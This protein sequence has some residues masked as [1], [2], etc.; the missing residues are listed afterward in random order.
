MSTNEPMSK[1]ELFYKRIVL[2]SRIAGLA[3]AAFGIPFYLGYGSPLPFSNPTYT[4]MDNVWLIV[5]PFMFVGLIVGLFFQKTGGLLVSIPLT[6]GLLLGLATDQ[7][8]VLHML[9][10]LTVGIL[11]LIIGFS[12]A[13]KKSKKGGAKE[14]QS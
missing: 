7:G 9:V 13:Y 10:P 8:L 4:L 2:F 5:F 14:K 12:K 6:A 1:T 11:Y 3:V